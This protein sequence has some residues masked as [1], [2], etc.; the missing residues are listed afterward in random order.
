MTNA[1]QGTSTRVPSASDSSQGRRRSYSRIRASLPMPD[2]VR[3]QLDSFSWF[4]REGLGELLGE[5]NPVSDFTGRIMDLRFGAHSF[6]AP[7]YSEVECRERDLTYAAPLR[8]RAELLIKETGEIKEQ[9]IFLGDFPLMTPHGTF[10]INGAERVVVSQLVRSPGAYFRDARD[11]GS[12]R[13]L[14]GAKLIPNRGAWLEFETTG[15]DAMYVKVDRK[16]KIPVTVLLRAVAA[17]PGEAAPAPDGSEP[18]TDA[19]LRSLYGAGGRHLEATIEKDPT[20]S[21]PEALVELYRRLRPGDPPTAE[22]ARSLL[23]SLLF[24][25]RR[26]DLAR[27]G[28]YK[29]TARWARSGLPSDPRVEGEGLRCA[30]GRDI[31]N[32]A[33]ELIRLNSSPSP[34]PADDIDHLGNRRVRAV[35]ELIQNQFRVGLLRMERVMKERMSIQD[36]ESATP[37][38][39]INIRPVVAA[40]REFFG[41]SQLSQFMEQTNT[42]SEVNHKRRLSAL[43]PGALNR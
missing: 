34:P 33:A 11:E 2:L 22:N 15:R 27:V 38:A 8:V 14:W 24:D 35:G 37:N 19:W 25:P 41:G 23:R 5:I 18:G 32:V 4:V 17:V 3:V 7:R 40:M 29:L 39:L 43:G 13:S 1:L 16:R 12:G 42:F 21:A 26:Y 9:D 6:G 10:V 20:K 31:A 36:A 28:R 30:T